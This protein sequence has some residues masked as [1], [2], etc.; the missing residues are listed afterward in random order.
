MRIIRITSGA[1]E[2]RRLNHSSRTNIKAFSG[3]R[4][5]AREKDLS[6]PQDIDTSS[7]ARAA[8]TECLPETRNSGREADAKNVCGA[9]T[10][11]ALHDIMV[12]A[13]TS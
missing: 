8:F 6:F 9:V 12:Y 13:V 3:P 10:P 5:C 1:Y 4:N 2:M 7:G 11:F